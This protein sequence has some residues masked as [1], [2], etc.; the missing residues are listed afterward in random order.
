MPKQDQLEDGPKRE[1]AAKGVPIRVRGTTG[2]SSRLK[3]ERTHDR[4]C[5]ATARLL[6]STSLRDLKVADIAALAGVSPATFYLYFADVNEAVLAVL[7]GLLRETPDLPGVIRRMDATNLRVQVRALVKAYLG[8][9]NDHYAVLRT[10]NLRADEADHRFRESRAQML[11][12]TLFALSEKMTELRGAELRRARVPPLAMA[13]VVMATLERLA[14]VI[15]LGPPAK[16]LSKRH[17]MD[18]AV[19]NIV[20]QLA[21]RDQGPAA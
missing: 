17:L 20:D 1:A 4:L 7:D 14:S 6:D 13:T 5:R 16:D 3:S 18:A 11:R 9:W 2:R 12:P 19:L 15:H 21:P 8:F 10:R